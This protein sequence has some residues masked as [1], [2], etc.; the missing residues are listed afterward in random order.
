M[1]WVGSDNKV[2]TVAPNDT[3]P[4]WSKIKKVYSGTEW[5]EFKPS[6]SMKQQQSCCGHSVSVFR[7]KLSSAV[8]IPSLY[9][10]LC[11]V[12]LHVFTS[13]EIDTYYSGAAVL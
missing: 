12:I 10:L 8:I 7:L 13:H 4:H 6:D 11:V 3:I 9:L 1:Y 2:Q 5:I